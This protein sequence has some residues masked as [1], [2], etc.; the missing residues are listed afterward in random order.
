MIYGIGTKLESKPPYK[1]RAL[2]TLQAGFRIRIVVC[3][4]FY[5]EPIESDPDSETYLESSDPDC[6]FS[7]LPDPDIF[8]PGANKVFF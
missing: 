2:V 7:D 1:K 6:D 5:F 4:L 8:F 3:R